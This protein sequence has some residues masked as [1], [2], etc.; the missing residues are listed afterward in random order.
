MR[1]AMA[2]TSPMTRRQL[3]T[4]A[5]AAVIP[6]PHKKPLPTGPSPLERELYK[7]ARNCQCA[8]LEMKEA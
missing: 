1:T 2:R 8:T 5:F 3:L 4:I 6:A 7:I